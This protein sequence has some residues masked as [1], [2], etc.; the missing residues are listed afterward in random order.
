[1]NVS[2][3]ALI[4]AILAGAMVWLFGRSSQR[5]TE[6]RLDERTKETDRLRQ[7]LT[8][9]DRAR[10]EAGRAFDL[11]SEQLQAD[12]T[13][14]LEESSRLAAEIDGERKAACE[15]LALLLDA[16]TKLR[17]A[18]KAL[19]AEALNAN[20]QSFLELAKTKLET[21]Q[22]TADSAFEAR[23]QAITVLV[24]PIEDSLKKVEER[25]GDVEKERVDA[26]AELRAHVEQMGRSQQQL[27]LETANL[28]R[29]LRTPHVRGQWGEI[30]LR[31]VV[32]MAGM[33]EQCDFA[34][35]ESTAT[36]QGSIRPDLI[37]KLPGGKS[38]VVDSKAPLSA[39]I[40]AAEA[41]DDTARTALMSQHAKQVRI[42]IEALASKGYWNQFPSAPDFVVM[43]LPGESFFSAACQYD[44]SLIEF[45]V[46]QH[47]IPAS[48]TTLITLLKT[49]QFGW[50]QERIAES[51]QHISA[52]GRELYDRLRVLGEHFERCG[53]GLRNAVD[54]Y[55]KAVGSLESR[56]LVS[57]RKFRELGSGSTD[58]IDALD[59]IDVNPK[60]LQ[61]DDW[62]T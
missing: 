23:K 18:F 27:Q 60:K 26:Y 30:Q 10:M 34:E 7:Q 36:D 4:A 31:R 8:E 42:H 20:N 61:A 57:A 49:V 14:A 51:A 56:V 24:K 2:V 3:V 38:I 53:N 17:E 55:N 58:D 52:L 29:A 48:P 39:Y 5:A 1:M 41:L 6:V 62:Q 43:F 9:A 16:E 59:V 32:E 47:V 45:A 21:H 28:V 54:H 37:V 35:Q 22:E 50:R 15:K 13:R 11:K 25:L 40:D 44:P 12:L 33:V 46:S 19:S